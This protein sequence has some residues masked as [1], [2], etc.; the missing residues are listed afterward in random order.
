MKKLCIITMIAVFILLCTNGM[1]A[2]TTQTQL[3]QVE[4]TKWF[5]GNWKD[6][7]A[8]DTTSFY[9]IKPYGTGLE[10]YF[11]DVTKGKIIL[12]GKQ[13]WGY[14]KK[15]D[16]FIMFWLNKG[17]GMD[18]WAVWFTSKN[19]FEW[20]LYNDISNPEK[21]SFKMEGEIKSPDMY[22]LTTIV[23]NKPIKTDTIT[24]VK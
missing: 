9:D 22:V 3:N 7:V 23:N 14:D 24:R 2:Q 17:T 8:K 19:R 20:V 10:G 21:A 6:E 18:I 1:Q 16:K 5:I 11:K 4:L 13:L 12:E 15:V